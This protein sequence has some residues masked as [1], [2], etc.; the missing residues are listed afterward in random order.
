MNMSASDEIRK[1]TNMPKFP[2]I[3]VQLVGQDG[4]AFNI[5]GL[6][7]RAMRRAGVEQSEIDAFIAEATAD[8]YDHLL[9]TVVA[10][11]SVC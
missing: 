4:N 10:T 6:V 1:D 7:Q 5:L 2:E 9:R 8:D 3:E 11:V